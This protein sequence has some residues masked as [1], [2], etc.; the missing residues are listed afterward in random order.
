MVSPLPIGHTS[1]PSE[2]IR[3]IPCKGCRP[4]VCRTPAKPSNPN[5]PGRPRRG[6]GIEWLR[7][8]L[9]A[10]AKRNGGSRPWVEVDLNRC[11]NAKGYALSWGRQLFRRLQRDAFWRK[12]CK[13]RYVQKRLEQNGCFVILVAF[14]AYLQWDQ[15]PLFY[16]RDRKT[17]RHV[18]AALRG[19]DIELR[20]CPQPSISTR[21]TAEEI[22][23]GT[24]VENQSSGYAEGKDENSLPPG[25]NKPSSEPTSHQTSDPVLRPSLNSRSACA[26]QHC[27][28]PEQSQRRS[29]GS[30]GTDPKGQASKEGNAIPV[31][32]R[33]F[34]LWLVF[35][36]RDLMDWTRRDIFDE[37]SATVSFDFATVFS[38]VRGHVVDGHAAN[39]I[40]S[41]WSKAVHLTHADVVDG[42]CRKPIALCVA[43]AARLLRR[44]DRT[45]QERIQQFYEQRAKTD[46]NKPVQEPSKN[47]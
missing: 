4:H 17:S 41:A 13:V 23:N 46:E 30:F 11:F 33:R 21:Q 29:T 40:R 25:Q 10:I 12:L 43:H 44:D 39:A 1:V 45:R 14:R 24:A 16:S 19:S 18:R 7:A 32:L 3:T 37:K 22:N 31:P 8:C 27:H 35:S 2:G 15:E 38:F 28:S 26:T 42:L 20:D 36:L 34:I 9:T 47:E 5:K 6:K